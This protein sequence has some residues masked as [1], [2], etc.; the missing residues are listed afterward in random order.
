M[1]KSTT[2]LIGLLLA[3]PVYAAEVEDKDLTILRLQK[4]VAEQSMGELLRD[5]RVSEYERIRQNYQRLLGEIEKK[6][7][8]KEEKKP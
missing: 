5:A 3:A 8:P 6:E 4:I 7:K 2:L 1:L